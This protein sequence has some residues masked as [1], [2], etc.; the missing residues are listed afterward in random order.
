MAKQREQPASRHS[1]PASVKILSKPSASA[2]F[3]IFI[4][5]GTPHIF[6]E[7]ATFLPLI[8]SAAACK[9]ERRPLVQLPTKAISIEV[10]KILDPSSKP[11]YSYASATTFRSESEKSLTLG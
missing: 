3:L 7:E 10:P 1:A 8:I 9:A 4:E 6:T 11:M 2:S 5:P